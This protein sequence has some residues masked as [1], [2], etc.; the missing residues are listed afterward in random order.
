MEIVN[1]PFGA[2]SLEKGKQMKLSDKTYNFLKWFAL[3]AIPALEA[4]WLTVG[5]VWNFPYLTEIG[6]TIAAVGLFIAA[7]IGVSSKN[8]YQIEPIDIEGMEYI[9]DGEVDEQD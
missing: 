4:F 2:F 3:V 9:E 7:L 8:Y 1:Q 6:T 5:K